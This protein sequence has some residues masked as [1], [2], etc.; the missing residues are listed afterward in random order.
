MT[1][2]DNVQP[3]DFENPPCPACFSYDV[4]E[5][6]PASPE[7][8]AADMQKAY[9]AGMTSGFIMCRTKSPV[10]RFLFRRTSKPRRPSSTPSARISGCHATRSTLTSGSPC[11]SP[12]ERTDIGGVRRP[13]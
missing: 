8:H 13:P 10:F 6:A 5:A 1:D 12:A 2:L 7:E 3:P 4:P 11:R 9:A